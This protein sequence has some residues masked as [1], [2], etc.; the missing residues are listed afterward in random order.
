MSLTS[1]RAAPPRD[2][3]WRYELP[4]LF[5]STVWLA[6]GLWQFQP[7]VFRVHARRY[8]V[9]RQRGRAVKRRPQEIVALSSK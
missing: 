5:R 9:Y 6:P 1:Y 8:P 4:D 3:P 7:A 2:N